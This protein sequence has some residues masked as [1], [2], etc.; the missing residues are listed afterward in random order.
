VATKQDVA[1]GEKV[2]YDIDFLRQHW[3]RF[4]NVLSVIPEA[5]SYQRALV[6]EMDNQE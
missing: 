6:L 4:L 2:F 5:Y 3:G 1:S